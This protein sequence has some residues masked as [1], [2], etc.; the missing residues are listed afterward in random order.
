M[1]QVSPFGRFCKAK[2]RAN[3]QL[4]IQMA[5]ATGIELEDLSLAEIGERQVEM[6]W[7]S[8]ISDFL[9]L[10]DF[11]KERLKR[12]METSTEIPRS[13]ENQPF[14]TAAYGGDPAEQRYEQ[15]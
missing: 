12:A 7:L 1:K 10:D 6:G 15:E 8:S 2:R 4:L 13:K 9:R 14:A 11:E 5:D 3:R